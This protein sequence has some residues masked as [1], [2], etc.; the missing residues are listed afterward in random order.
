MQE[1]SPESGVGEI[2]SKQETPAR[3][4]FLWQSIFCCRG[5]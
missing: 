4:R 1:G 5:A 3:W 2:E